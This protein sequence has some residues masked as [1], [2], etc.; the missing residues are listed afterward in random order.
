MHLQHFIW[1]LWSMSRVSWH[2]KPDLYISLCVA[3]LLLPVRW[4]LAW[5]LAAFVHELCHYTVLRLCGYRVLGISVGASGAEILTEEVTGWKGVLCALA[6][7]AG[8]LL[9]LFLLH[10][11]PRVAL[12]GFVQSFYNLL[13]IYP[14]DGGQAVESLLHMLPNPMLADRIIRWVERSVIAVL[15]GAGVY[16]V[17][18][19]DL[20]ILPL[21]MIA[22][23]LWKT[24]KIKIPCKESLKRV[25]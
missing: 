22:A 18:F 24:G 14:L 20:G 13:P 2:I 9:L 12:C 15:V 10:V 23:F 7:P 8:G 3:I 16:A 1:K 19:L 4:V 5:F 6:G 11:A 21:A 17:I 25:Q